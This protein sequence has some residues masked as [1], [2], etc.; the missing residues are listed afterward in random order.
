[1]RIHLLLHREQVHPR[2]ALRRHIEQRFQRG[3]RYDI[4]T[5][6]GVVQ[7]VVSDIAVQILG[8]FGTGKLGALRHIHKRAQRG[9]YR[10]R[11]GKPTAFAF[12]FVVGG[13]M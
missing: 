13:R 12:G 5:V 4:L 3:I 6:F 10:I 7:I 11:F 8:H 1:M 9:G 2:F